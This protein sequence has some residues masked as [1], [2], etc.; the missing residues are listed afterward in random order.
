METTLIGLV[1]VQTVC[2]NTRLGHKVASADIPIVH[3]KLDTIP[4]AVDWPPAGIAA[5]DRH[6][7]AS[8]FILSL[9]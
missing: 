5:L 6:Y 4:T 9:C 2:Y 7:D 3:I 8:P 1:V